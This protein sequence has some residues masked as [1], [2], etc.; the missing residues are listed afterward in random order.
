MAR[1]TKKGKEVEKITPE[2][3]TRADGELNITKIKNLLQSDYPSVR[4]DVCR[5]LMDGLKATKNIVA[6][7]DLIT[8]P[9]YPTRLRYAQAIA[10]LLGEGEIKKSS[11]SVTV[12]VEEKE[13]LA[14]IR[15]RVFNRN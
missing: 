14:A 12:T 9:D 8:D 10:E 4:S 13:E 3:I 5:V 15:G 11:V 7:D 6:D 2:S 1:G